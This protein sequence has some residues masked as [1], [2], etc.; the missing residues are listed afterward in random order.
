MG[1]AHGWGRGANMPLFRLGSALIYFAHVPKCAGTA[2][3][4]YLEARFGTLAFV[5]RRYLSQPALERWTVSSPQHVPRAALERLFPEHF[6]DHSFAIVRH[7]AYRLR[8][9]FLFQRDIEETI[10]AE[11][12]F[13]D[14]LESL[15]ALRQ[16][17]PFALDNHIRPM[18]ELVPEGAHLFRLE[19]GLAPVQAWLDDLAGGSDD[20]V[21]MAEINGYKKR[22]W[23]EKRMPRG[24]MPEMTLDI[25]RQ[26]HRL[27]P[28]D[29]G[30]F[31]YDWESG[32]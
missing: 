8:S 7:P 32:V 18:A 4:R 29:F 15:P 12:P 2:I 24:E 10:P 6:F 17:T 13:S 9:V 20:S 31:G 28:E 30:R 19:Q 1:W 5:D 3:E 26:V 25:F 22:M 14:W 11:L 16:E 23:R 21:Q 27:Y